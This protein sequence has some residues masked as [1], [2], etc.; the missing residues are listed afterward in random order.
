MILLTA[1]YS[2]SSNTMFVMPVIYHL[3]HY[4]Q[5]DVE[6]FLL[7]AKKYTLI[8]IFCIMVNVLRS[9]VV[10]KFQVT[11]SDCVCFGFSLFIFYF[12]SIGMSPLIS[13]K[14]P[15]LSPTIELVRACV[16]VKYWQ[17]LQFFLV[18]S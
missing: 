4:H 5:F 3:I 10:A 7:K 18:F 17:L 15:L 11:H 2:N 12:D 13:L 14:V 8:G 6:K 16:G 1:L 9:R